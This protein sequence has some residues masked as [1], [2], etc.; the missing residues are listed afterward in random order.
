MTLT[1][2]TI[3]EKLKILIVSQESNEFIFLLK[4]ELKKYHADFFSSPLLPRRLSDFD[5]CFVIGNNTLPKHLPDT[6]KIIIIIFDEHSRNSVPSRLIGTGTWVKNNSNVKIIH[7]VGNEI[8]KEDVD[9]ILWFSLSTGTEKT[10]VLTV[11]KRSKPVFPP[12]FKKKFA[13]ISFFSLK[14]IFLFT[15]ILFFLFH[16]GCMIPLVMTSNTF[17]HALDALQEQ[18]FDKAQ[19]LQIQGDMYLRQTKKW[20]SMVRPTYLLFS[21]ALIPDTIIDINEKA[22]TILTITL[23]LKHNAT[24]IFSFLLNKN[25]TNEDKKI[26]LLRMN[27]IK[28]ESKQLE[29]QISL[30]YQKIP[31][32]MDIFKKK[33]EQIFSL[34]E[35]LFKINTVFPYIDTLLGK[36]E[37]KTYLLL[38]ANNMELRPGGGFIGSFCIIRIKDYTLEDLKIYDVYDADGQLKAHLD[39]P[40]PIREYLKQPHWFLRDSA[41]SPDFLENYAQA[42]FFLEKEMNFNHFDGAFLIT[43]SAIEKILEAF[44]DIYLPDYKETINAKNFYLKAQ[45]HSE[46]DFFPGS[47]A[48]KGFLFSLTNT[49]FLQ[50]EQVSLPSLARAIKQSLDEKQIVLYI[51][52][53]AFQD[54]MDSFYW[55]G[56]VF[57]PKCTTNLPNCVADYLFP[58]D[59]NLGVN[60]ANFF[61]KRSMHLKTYI[62]SQGVITHTLFI[63]FTNESPSEV[64]P[65]GTYKNFFQVLLPKNS[66]IKAI[67]K[68]DVLVESVNQKNEEFT[69][70]G[71][72][73]EV[74]PKTTVDIKIP[75]ELE[76]RLQKGNGVYQLIVQKQIGSSNND[77]I[78]ELNIPKNIYVVNKNFSPLVKQNQ[79][80]YNTTLTTDKIFFIEVLKE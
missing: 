72:Y 5:Y 63:R 48:K 42:K 26:F 57:E 11:R 28:Q 68:N 31:Q 73:F 54:L 60:K 16:A 74:P 18:R 2:E 36:D 39:P 33:R 32:N 52:H 43:T 80:L 50:L 58:I 64:F 3:E 53:P 14:R 47:T 4:S 21:L 38:F 6:K 78:F 56:R 40:D 70:V 46:K 13:L 45:I 1:T 37:E 59:A 19:T 65:G 62:N 51:D 24:Y 41:F 25:K 69:T 75:Y 44:G 29:K 27:K 10:L 66:S 30:L 12:I 67:T 79:M 23:D 61:V 35:L 34:R 49:M 8:T 71:F 17:Y 20:Y 9:K 55:S 76:M 22:N 7:I 15:G 77:F